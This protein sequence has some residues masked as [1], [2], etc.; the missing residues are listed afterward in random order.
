MTVLIVDDQPLNLKLLKAILEEQNYKVYAAPDGVEALEI[1]NHE[2]IDAIISDILMPRMDGYRLCSEVRKHPR[3]GKT[4]FIFYTATYDSPAD[5]KLCYDLGADKYL[6]KPAPAAKIQETLTTVVQSH[7]LREADAVPA[8]RFEESE[9]MKQYSEQL[10]LKLE[11]KNT[12]LQAAVTRLEQSEA[13]FTGAFLW[14]PAGM[15]L[16]EL[17][18]GRLV[19]VNEKFLQIFEFTRAE[20]I[21]RS[22]AELG[23]ISAEERAKIARATKEKGYLPYETIEARSKTGATRFIQFSSTIIEIEGAQYLLMTALDITESRA[24][25]Q[26]LRLREAELEEAQ[27][28]AQIGSWEADL[29]SQQAAWSAEQFRLLGWEPQEKT[30]TFEDYLS[31]VHPDDLVRFR[32]LTLAAVKNQEPFIV[33]YRIVK[34][35][36]E[37]RWMQGRG[38]IILDNAG[39]AI[40]LR[41]TNQD[42]TDRKI[43]ED[44][45]RESELLFRQLAENIREIFYLIDPQ[46]TQMFYISPTYEEVW[47][48]SRESLYAD[49]RAWGEAIHPDDRARVFAEVAPEGTLVAGTSEYRIVRPDGEIR[50]IRARAFPILDNSGKIYRFAGTAEDITGQ[51]LVELQLRQS[52]KM[53]AIGQ[54]SGGVAHDFN[55]LLTVILGHANTLAESL[56][57]AGAAESI[58]EIT[59]AAERA[60]NL[61]RQLLLFARKQ[62]MQMENLDVNAVVVNTIKMLARILGEDIQLDF[63]PHHSELWVYADA[64]MLD[65]ILLNLAV[66]ARDAM[67]AGGRLV[68]ETA[69]ATFDAESAAQ[70]VQIRPGDFAV[71]SVTDSGC[72]IPADILPKIFDPFF[73][74]KGVDKGTGLGLSTVFG[75]V[76]QHE[77]W[78]S[79]YSEE[80]MGATFRIYLP[81]ARKAAAETVA[82]PAAERIHG[83]GETL[84]IVEDDDAIRRMVS[85]FLTNLGYEVLLASNGREAL[86]VFTARSE[87]IHLLFTDLVMPGDINGVELSRH[88]LSHNAQLKV[89]YS[90]GY[91]DMLLAGKTELNAGFNFLAKPFGLADIAKLI[92]LR[93]DEKD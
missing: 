4:P 45:L 7:S 44:A 71:I 68:I 14:N 58:T 64:G 37:I 80:N 36:G 40:R 33:E 20:A 31:M 35:S 1:L 50:Y 59:R 42:I 88:L 69:R 56:P 66:N 26:K 49:A 46:M 84:L 34:K 65:Q 22:A 67:S 24:A 12:E 38:E 11:Q 28:I 60:A 29:A 47:G 83:G 52:Q 89:I 8:L 76:Q 70:S 43:A 10:V 79:V 54:L 87:D 86:Q 15:T 25:E 55:N 61:T 75:I 91:S 19:D 51:R 62:M 39:N 72:G 74:T 63:R 5:E 6:L 27:R 9:V 90:S 81:L 13:K 21:G 48:R 85:N 18:T 3:F 82:K 78:V 23:I 77:G 57:E 30:F 41:G 73:T 93:L 2:P 92:R 32:D 16:A 17:A 53:E